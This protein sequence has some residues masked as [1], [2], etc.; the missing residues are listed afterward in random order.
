M[1]PAVAA[2]AAT[3]ATAAA[4]LL[5]AAAVRAEPVAHAIDPT[6]S[7]VTFEVRHFGTSTTRGR[8]A[9]RQGTIELDKAARSGRAEI[10]LDTKTVDSGI[11]SFDDHLRNADFFDV[12]V[13]PT[14]RFVSD[15]FVFEG[16]KLASVPGQLTLLG[17]TLPVTLTATHYNCYLNP[18]VKR[19]VCGGDFETTIQR[20]RWGMNFGLPGIPDDVHLVIQIEAA[21]Q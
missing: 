15:R 10:T 14:A 19:E 13:H 11:P 1:K 12:A 2:T 16:D 6:H 3:A 18:R 5:A 8:F 7:F 17:K 9:V 21:R 4:L 20:S